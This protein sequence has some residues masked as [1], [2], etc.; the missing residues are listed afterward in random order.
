MQYYI[1]TEFDGHNGPLLSI[2]MVREDDYSIHIQ[3]EAVPKDPWVIENV[4][5]IM[6]CHWANR[7]FA[8]QQV[9]QV[10]KHL[11]GFIGSDEFPIIHADSAVDIMRFTQAITTNADGSW[12]PLGIKRIAFM[13]H[14][15]DCYPTMLDNAV[16][17]NAWWDA[18]ALRRK[19]TVPSG[20]VSVPL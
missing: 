19:L 6:N 9:N 11:L 16:R 2:A 15:I 7:A 8:H 18:Q 20:Q 5:P 17:H 13:V 1:D 12:R 10:G 4:M 14:D 3:T